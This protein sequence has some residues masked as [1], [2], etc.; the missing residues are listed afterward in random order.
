MKRIDRQRIG[1]VDGLRGLA[2]VGILL[3]NIQ[4]FASTFHGT[5]IADPS[6]GDG[7]SGATT[8]IVDALFETKFYLL[9]SFLFGYSF[10][11][12]LAGA[13]RR[14]EPVTSQFTRRLLCLIGLGTLHAVLLFPGDIL[15]TYGLVGFALLRIRH[16]PAKKALRVGVAVLVVT[17]S[18]YALLG[19][20][21]LAA[22]DEASGAA[23]I[24][25]TSESARE[26]Y[27]GSPAQVITQN[28]SDLSDAYALLL[29]FQAPSALA[30]F[31]LGYAAGRTD[32]LRHPERYMQLWRKGAIG[33]TAI[34]LL[35]GALYAWGSLEPAMH[36]PARELL[37][38][39]ADVIL[40]PC[41]ALG[42]L[43]IT[44]LIFMSKRGSSVVKAL[45][46]AGRLALTNYLAQSMLMALIFTGY[47]LGLVG[48]VSPPATVGIA[49][50]IF[51]L[52]VL[53]SRL[54][55]RSGPR[56]GPAEA[57]LRGATRWCR[58]TTIVPA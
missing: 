31:C 56:Y 50:G 3:V 23:S 46:P 35:G 49:I 21:S 32:V 34:G 54:Y 7:I 20:A 37:T 27:Q 8:A 53:W 17:A 5:G 48:D 16:W 26:S 45:A 43:S 41:L 4:Y 15:A 36:A 19:L 14:G 58:P 55:L 18:V 44:L 9:F 1:Y 52:E 47:G 10:T 42:Y 13:E 39:A 30:M 28:V 33:G 51:G 6:Y 25:R 40:A 29:F 2:L 11:L 12:W 57:I 22:G 38:V 24:T